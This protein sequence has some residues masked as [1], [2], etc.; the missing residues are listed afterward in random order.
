MTY[1]NFI[2]ALNSIGSNDDER[3][4]LL[5]TPRRTLTRYKAGQFPPIIPRLMR[6]PELLHALAED[7]DVML[8]TAAGREEVRN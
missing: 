2:E 4:L 1:E 8:A 6:Y 7:A 3:A 5:G